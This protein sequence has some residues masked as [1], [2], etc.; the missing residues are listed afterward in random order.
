[1]INR[2]WKK[3]K[4]KKEGAKENDRQP[5]RISMR[6]RIKRKNSVFLLK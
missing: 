1:M 6:G 3:K 2:I 4:T 5:L